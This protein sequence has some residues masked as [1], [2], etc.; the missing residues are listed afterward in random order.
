MRTDFY[1]EMFLYTNLRYFAA[2]IIFVQSS[3]WKFLILHIN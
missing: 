3:K 2:G 1:P